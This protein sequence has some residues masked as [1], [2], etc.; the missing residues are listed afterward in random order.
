[1]TD[2]T[3]EEKVDY[4]EHEIPV[5][6]TLQTS[7]VVIHEYSNLYDKLKSSYSVRGKR[8]LVC[9]EL[10]NANLT[11]IKPHIDY[12]EYVKIGDW[13]SILEEDILCNLQ[14]V[15]SQV[16]ECSTQDWAISKDCRPDLHAFE[17]EKKKTKCMKL[18]FHFVMWNKKVNISLL[19]QFIAEQMHQFEEKLLDKGLDTSIYRDG[20]NKFRCPMTKK[21]PDCH[22]SLLAPINFRKKEDFHKHLVTHISDC[23]EIELVVTNQI[24]NKREKVGADFV[25]KALDTTDEIAAI[26]DGYNTKSEKAGDGDYEGCTFYD[27]EDYHCGNEHNNN[28]NYLIHNK[29]NN[30]LKIKCHSKRCEDFEKIV[31]KPKAP[32][33]NFEVEYLNNIPIDKDSKSNYF[34]VRQYFENFII[35]IRDTN[36]FYRLDYVWDNKYKVHERDL[37]PIKIEGYQNDLY[38]MERDENGKDDKKNFIKDYLRDSK[39]NA[40]Y[41]IQFLPHSADA[42]NTETGHYNL[43]KGFNFSR[44]LNFFEK[45]NIPKEKHEDLAFLK[46]HILENVCDGDDKAYDYLMQWLAAIIQNPAKVAQIILIF[47]SKINGTGKSG[48]TKFLA[49]VLGVDLTFF[50]S[51]TQIT[52]THTHAHVGKLFNVIEEVDK[53]ITR[54]YKNIIKDISQREVAIYN[55]K[56][57]PQCRMKTFVR[58]IMTTNYHDGVNFDSEDRRY[59]VYNFLKSN[60]MKYVNKLIGILEDKHVIF[61]FGQYLQNYLV[62]MNK[63]SDWINNRPLNEHYYNMRCEDSIDAFLKDFTKLE[64]IEVD[65]LTNKEYQ[66]MDESLTFRDGTE[67]EIE[68]I[69]VKKDVLFKSLYKEYCKDNNNGFAKGKNTFYASLKSNYSQ[70]IKIDKIGKKMAFKVDIKGLFEHFFPDEVYVNYHDQDSESYQAFVIREDNKSKKRREDRQKKKD[71]Q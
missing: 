32:T 54:K 22:D 59:V 68:Y 53:T 8:G 56:N 11:M 20:F 43:F 16:F 49:S 1:M 67:K 45:E 7:K 28:N 37:K 26:I 24:D 13:S 17:G 19:R 36:S 44:V 4:L 33:L 46:K 52:E 61:L 40:Y 29:H 60:D 55:E 9:F 42:K 50:G 23:E 3:P 21:A 2:G 39:K 66:T 71:D 27:L 25:Q 14:D 31:Y 47:F 65:E 34:A 30:T 35:F 12:E 18:S 41:N 57:K 6:F 62:T 58:Y 51:L 69:M 63:G 10:Y 38:F 5:C 70:Y 15:L 48:F 64:C